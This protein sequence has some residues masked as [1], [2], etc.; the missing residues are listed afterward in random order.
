MPPAVQEERGVPASALAGL[1]IAQL[2]DLDADALAIKIEHQ[3]CM[4]KKAILV[5]SMQAY[6]HVWQVALI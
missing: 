2:V 3:H 1:S 5:G 4:T 6:V